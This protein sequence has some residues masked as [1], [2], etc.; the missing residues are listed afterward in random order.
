MTTKQNTDYGDRKFPSCAAI[1]DILR[2]SCTFDSTKD[3]L[4]CLNHLCEEINDNKNGENSKNAGCLRE[5]VRIKNGFSDIKNWKNESQCDYKDI[6]LNVIIYDETTDQSMIVEIQLLL[7]WLLKAKKVGHKIYGI[8]RKKEFINSVNQL[9]IKYDCN[10]K[11]YIQRLDSIIFSQ[12]YHDFAM[13]LFLNPNLIFSTLKYQQ[14]HIKP[15]ALFWSCFWHYSKHYFNHAYDY[16]EQ[17]TDGSGINFV[18]EYLN[19]NIT[20]SR[21]QQVNEYGSIFGI[22]LKNKSNISIEYQLIDLILKN[23]YYKGLQQYT[24][25][26]M[27]KMIENITSTQ[28]GHICTF[29]IILKYPK[30][31]GIVIV[32]AIK[33]G[34]LTVSKMVRAIH[35]NEKYL[36]LILFGTLNAIKEMNDTNDVDSDKKKNQNSE[37]G[38]FKNN[39]LQT[40]YNDCVNGWKGKNYLDHKPVT[41]D[42]NSDKAK[43][44]AQMIKKYAD[45][46]NQT[47][48]VSS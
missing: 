42:K 25:L 24:K 29:E 11:N 28:D 16:D 30:K 44:W 5:I 33:Q 41:I 10:Y 15:K 19:Y 39:D 8:K 31:N 43:K 22:G 9:R 38:I 36:H 40:A 20:N 21:I 23:R 6:K 2:C 4:N 1:C 37:I 27:N 13:Q 45:A 17:E 14:L 34:F 32:N 47:L 7:T 12:N 3:M 48:K 35:C 26:E 18:E 46:T